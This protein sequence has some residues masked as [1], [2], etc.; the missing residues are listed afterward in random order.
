MLTA[1]QLI[2]R[3]IVSEPFENALVLINSLL[4]PPESEDARRA[5]RHSD[6]A[7]LLIQSSEGKLRIDMIS[8]LIAAQSDP[9]RTSASI[10]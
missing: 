7:S 6:E 10:L 1:T 4:P 8:L 5:M 2:R 9:V 3:S